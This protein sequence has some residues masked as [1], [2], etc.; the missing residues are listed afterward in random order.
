MQPSLLHLKNYFVT[1]LSVK[2]N[3]VGGGAQYKLEGGVKTQTVTQTAQSK[4]NPRDWRVA[5]KI[6]C[7]PE[8]TN[9]CA[10]HVDLEIVGFFEAD[11]RLPDAKVADFMTANCPALL[12]GAAREIVLLVTGRGPF[13]PFTLP[14][15]TFVD[16]C[17]SAKN[18][19]SKTAVAELA[20]TG[21]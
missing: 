13:P 5:L 10:Y 4:S 12:Y 19:L 14:A 11:K 18:Q 9:L 6:A 2:A 20:K 3:Q 21:K 16:D 8:Q 7:V 1:N 17:P 15:V